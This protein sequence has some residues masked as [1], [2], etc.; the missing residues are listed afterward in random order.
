MVS[1][2]ESP[3][4]RAQRRRVRSVAARRESGW[5]WVDR[6]KLSTLSNRVDGSVVP[7]ASRPARSPGI[8]LRAPMW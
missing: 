4:V 1:C 7:V 8:I 3:L 2:I 6:T 5:L